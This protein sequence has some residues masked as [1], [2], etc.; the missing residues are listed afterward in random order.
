MGK[1]VRLMRPVEWVKNVVVLAGPAFAMRLFDIEALVA[2]AAFCLAASAVY[3]VNDIVDREADKAHPDKR[4]RPIASGAVTPTSAAVLAV[5]L[6]VVALGVT[7]ISA[8]KALAIIVASYIVLIFAYSF[9]LKRQPILDVIVIATGFVLRAVGGAAAVSAPVSPWLI[10]CTFTLCMFLGFGKRRCELATL[11]NRD[12]AGAHRTTLLRYTPELLNHLTSVSAG[13]AI[14]T[15]LLYT[16]DASPHIPPPPFRKDYLLYTLPLVAYAL[17]RY[18]M[19]IEAGRF[20]GPTQIVMKDKALILTGVLWVV[21]VGGIIAT[22]GTSPIR[23]GEP[24]P[25]RV[26]APAG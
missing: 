10:A 7:Y 18:A 20:S 6:I 4:D 16:M 5:V 9:L 11:T 2:F 1:Y 14:M 21:A 17:F 8:P 26:E 12:D 15:F 3:V 25:Q 22:T 19:L 13:I 24:P 23:G